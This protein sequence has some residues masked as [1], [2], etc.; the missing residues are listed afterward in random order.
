MIAFLFLSPHFF[1][2]FFIKRKIQF[3]GILVFFFSLGSSPIP[4][5]EHTI[6]F[7]VLLEMIFISLDGVDGSVVTVSQID[8]SFQKAF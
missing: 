2:F 1:F 7:Y 8:R 6:S 3:H 4:E 5:I